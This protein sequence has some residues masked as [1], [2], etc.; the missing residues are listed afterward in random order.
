MKQPNEK[1]V[2][3]STFKIQGRKNYAYGTERLFR[4]CASQVLNGTPIDEACEK[5]FGRVS[6]PLKDEIRSFISQISSEK[7]ERTYLSEHRKIPISRANGTPSSTYKGKD[8][9][10]EI[11]RRIRNDH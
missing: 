8:K 10:Q 1:E 4:I 5:S 3:E 6:E 9:N 11:S 7:N 2:E